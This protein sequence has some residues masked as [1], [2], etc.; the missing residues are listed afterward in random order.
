MSKKLTGKPIII[1][2]AGLIGRRALDYFGNDKVYCFADNF[3]HGQNFRGKPVISFEKLVEIASGYDI[4]AAMNIAAMREVFAQ[5]TNASVKINDFHEYIDI[6]NFKSNHE[7]VKFHNI[8]K[9]KRC[10]LIGNGPSLRIEDLDKLY[11]N[12][13]ITF[14]CNFIYKIFPQTPWRPNYYVASDVAFLNYYTKEIADAEV[15]IK[16]IAEP[17]I[18]VLEKENTMKEILEAGK[19]YCYYYYYYKNFTFDYSGNNYF[20]DDPSKAI[21]CTGTVMY[22]MIQLAVYMGFEKI[23]LIGVDATTSVYGCKDYDSEIRHFYN[24]PDLQIRKDIINLNPALTSITHDDVYL[25][26]MY[27]FNCAEIY[28]RTHNFRI[29]NATR[30]G[31]LEVFERVDFDLLFNE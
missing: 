10:F 8:H 4:V 15:E 22:A 20:S 6:N 5:S 3:K 19:G 28:S 1:F 14:G 12:G 2:G 7:I 9:G 13:E 23:Y 11:A 26:M 30:G 21:P 29:Y 16:F 18:V 17:K 25:C 24:E 31:K 27:D